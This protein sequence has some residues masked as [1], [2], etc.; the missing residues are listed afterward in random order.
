MYSLFLLH[1]ILVLCTLYVVHFTLQVIRSRIKSFTHT[2]RP[3][4]HDRFIC[5]CS[6][7]I[8]RY[9]TKS[10]VQ[11]VQYQS[12]PS[13]QYT[14]GCSVDAAHAIRAQS[15]EGEVVQMSFAAA[16]ESNQTLLRVYSLHSR[17]NSMRWNPLE[18][19]LDYFS[20][21]SECMAISASITD[22]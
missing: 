14:R 20:R 1:L 2:Q 19:L 9:A 3:A 11:P 13:L 17:F 5:N 16:L 8:S 4:T 6:V 18:C 10:P 21:M 22:Y 12:S 7:S 15:T